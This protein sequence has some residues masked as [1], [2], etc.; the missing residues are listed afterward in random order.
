VGSGFEVEIAIKG[1]V[2]AVTLDALGDLGAE[3]VP[4]HCVVLVA[5]GEVADLV[6]LL[7][8]LDARGVEVDRITH[9]SSLAGALPG[10]SLSR[11][12]S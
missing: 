10:P 7:A 3:I 11:A 8:R 9:P 12:L 4:R 2:G 1:R 5:S 6:A